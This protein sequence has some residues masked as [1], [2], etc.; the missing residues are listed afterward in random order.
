MT[1]VAIN[2]V[3]PRVQYVANGLTT[4]FGFDFVIFDASNLSV[5][6]NDAEVTTGFTIAG[7]NEEDGG[8]VTFS[9][10]PEYGQKVTLKRSVPY[11]RENDYQEGAPIRASLLNADLDKLTAMIQQLDETDKR[12]AKLP[13]TTSFVGELEMPEPSAGEAI[14][15]NE[16]GTGLTNKAI[17]AASVIEAANIL[18]ANIDAFNNKVL[19][20]YATDELAISAAGSGLQE[21]TCYY[22]TTTHTMRYY[23]GTV[24]IDTSSGKVK[25]N[26][27]TGNGVQTSFILSDAPITDEAVSVYI[28]GVY[29]NH[30]EFSVSGQTL[31]FTEAPSSGNEIEVVWVTPLSV[32]N[33]DNNDVQNIIEDNAG[34]VGGY[35]PLDADLQIPEAY[36]GNAAAKVPT[37]TGFKAFY[38]TGAYLYLSVGYASYPQYGTVEGVLEGPHP[39]EYD[40]YGYKCVGLTLTRAFSE[41]ISGIAQNVADTGW[42]MPTNGSVFIHLATKD[43]DPSVVRYV[44]NSSYNSIAL[45]GWTWRRCVKALVTN[46]S[47]QLYPFHERTDGFI[48]FDASIVGVSLFSLSGAFST[49]TVPS[50][51]GIKNQLEIGVFWGS[52]STTVT[53]YLATFD[54]DNYTTG[55]NGERLRQIDMMSGD[56][57][58]LTSIK[59]ITD[60][61]SRIVYWANGDDTF[62]TRYMQINAYKPTGLWS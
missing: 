48:Q 22:N 45:S 32:T 18:A 36:L 30:T 60:S 24:F 42:T 46:S 41:T 25:V 17:D 35:P 59:A 50:P 19:G 14:C 8:S 6:I 47:A 5:F 20:N 28:G 52:N 54:P 37:Y 62:N 9:T 53:G 26:T 40:I 16:S 61:S 43:S 34:I 2:E 12:S 27:F 51:Y 1:D 49:V 23:N 33:I 31:T 39:F 11:K 58:R 15:W 7:V 55:T 3:T 10:A 44:A 56:K 38:A 57:Q 13:A 21:G 4:V 29:Q